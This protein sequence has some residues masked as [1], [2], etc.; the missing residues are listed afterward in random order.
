MYLPI[1]NVVKIKTNLYKFKITLKDQIFIRKNMIKYEYKQ[2]PSLFN[3]IN[4][5]LNYFSYKVMIFFFCWKQINKLNH[6]FV[7]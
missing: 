6:Q 2:K 1:D 4:T 7:D 3:Q 5:T